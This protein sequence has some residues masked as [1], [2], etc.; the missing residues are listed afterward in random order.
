MLY[1]SCY[2][3]RLARNQKLRKIKKTFLVTMTIIIVVIA[4]TTIV[5]IMITTTTTTTTIDLCSVT[6]KM[7]KWMKKNKQCLIVF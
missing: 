7:Q 6:T 4:W 3:R 2:Y 5:V 1:G